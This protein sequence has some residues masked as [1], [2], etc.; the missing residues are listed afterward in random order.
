[1]GYLR[2]RR[3]RIILIIICCAVLLIGCENTDADIQPTGTTRNPKEEAELRKIL[4][5]AVFETQPPP[6]TTSYQ[7]VVALEV[8]DNNISQII[9]S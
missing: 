4:D 6:T 7:E 3:N 5:G 1:M 2:N 8:Y 9:L